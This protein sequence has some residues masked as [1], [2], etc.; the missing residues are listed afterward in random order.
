MRKTALFAP[1]LLASCATAPTT[2]PIHGETPGHACV[3]DAGDRFVG[4]VAVDSTGPAILSAT[5]AAVLRWAPPGAMMT[6]DFRSDRVT[7]WLDAGNRITKV[8]CG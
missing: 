8:R 1:V 2:P 6:M 3:E 5:H 7:V 4:Q